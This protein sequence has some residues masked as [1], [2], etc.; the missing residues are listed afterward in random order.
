MYVVGLSLLNSACQYLH[1]YTQSRTGS[2][3]SVRAIAQ[4]IVA[5]E[6]QSV[7]LRCIPRPITAALRWTFGGGSL[8]SGGLKFKLGRLN[9]TL[10]IR[11][12]T[13]ENSGE[14]NCHVVGG[15]DITAT[16]DLNV[17]AGTVNTCIL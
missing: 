2:P 3:S 12:L 15:D 17:T 1:V 10:F 14:Y 11:N 7:N 16:I 5:L 8:L 4:R 6:G 9:Q 13:M